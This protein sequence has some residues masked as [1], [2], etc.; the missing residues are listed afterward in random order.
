MMTSSSLDHFKKDRAIILSFNE[1]FDIF[2][3]DVIHICN[4]IKWRVSIST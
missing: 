2:D 4:K 1:T 3:I